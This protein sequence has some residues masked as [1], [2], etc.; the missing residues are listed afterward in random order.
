M[1]LVITF[2]SVCTLNL[3]CSP[4]GL[5]IKKTSSKPCTNK[6]LG[7]HKVHEDGWGGGEV[8]EFNIFQSPEIDFSCSL[9]T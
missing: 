9:E 6:N 2:M 1:A 4:V 7:G 3:S 5:L 8:R